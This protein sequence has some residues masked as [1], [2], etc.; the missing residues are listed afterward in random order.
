MSI[1]GLAFDDQSTLLWD[2]PSISDE[3]TFLTDTHP[4]SQAASS[5]AIGFPIN[6]VSIGAFASPPRSS[7]GAHNGDVA[8][9]DSVIN[10]I[11]FDPS[12]GPCEIKTSQLMQE[13]L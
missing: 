13:D 3:D 4:A 6:E 7:N 1:D 2:F 9:Q 5:T 11:S 8:V 10:A 12:N